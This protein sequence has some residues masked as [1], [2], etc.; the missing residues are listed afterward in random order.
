MCMILQLIILSTD[1]AAIQ[2]VHKYLM[3]KNNIKQCLHLLK[4]CL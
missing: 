1:V 3:N 4:K 2:Y